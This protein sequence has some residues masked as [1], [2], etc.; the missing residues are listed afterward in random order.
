M[1]EPVERRPSTARD[2]T[3]N[4]VVLGQTIQASLREWDGK[5]WA[6]TSRLSGSLKSLEPTRINWLPLTSYCWS[7][8]TMSLYCTASEINGDFGRKWQISPLPPV[9][10]RFYFS[11]RV[12]QASRS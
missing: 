3:P 9:R 8:A 6:F 11:E 4:L 2:T 12:R 5:M 1:A 7:I 10:S